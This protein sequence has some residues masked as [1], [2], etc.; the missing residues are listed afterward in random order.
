MNPE[1][2]LINPSNVSTNHSL[3]SIVQVL[4]VDKIA[5]DNF[6]EDIAIFQM[7]ADCASLKSSSKIP[8]T[9]LLPFKVVSWVGCIQL[10]TQRCGSCQ[11]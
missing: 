2:L 1:D 10:T 7:E 11:I 6:K 9:P 3:L 4:E 8:S 5:R